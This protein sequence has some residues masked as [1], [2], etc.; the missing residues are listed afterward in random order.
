MWQ[1]L[2]T[3]GR[4]GVMTFIGAVVRRFYAD[5]CLMRASALAYTSLLSMVPLFAIM[6]AA[7][8]G[9]G[10]Q[11]RLETLLLSRLSLSEDT[12]M[13]IIGYIDRT[14]VG[15]LGAIGAATLVLTVISVLGTIEASFNHIWRVPRERS[16]WRKVT[17]YLGV[18][19]LTPFLLLAATALTSAGQVKTV[20]QWVLATGYVG[21]AAVW[22]LKLVPLAMNVIALGALYMIM[23]NRRGAPLPIAV[24][25]LFAG[26]AWHLVQLA[27]VSLQIGVAQ[28]DAIYGAVAQLPVTLVWLYVSWAV[29]LAGAELA[30]VLEFGVEAALSRAP[31]RGDAVAL[32]LLVRA[33]DA[34]R[35]G[36][37]GISLRRAARELRVD[38]A[39]VQD[40]A[41]Q[42]VKRGWLVRVE[43][44]P[45]WVVLARDP[46]LVPLRDVVVSGG[47]E[48]IPVRCD[49]R[50]RR[51]LELGDA[52]FHDALG[53]LHLADVLGASEAGP[54]QHGRD[55]AA[56]RQ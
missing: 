43:G 29:V 30:A 9:L 17:D 24:G 10:V 5:Q 11:H 53:G 37:S 40:A 49:P 22:L 27:Y 51:V 23:P 47:S 18:V 34:F 25:A 36:H 16:V 52:A 6:F 32:H 15:T 12:T 55:A 41:E 39:V 46:T 45:D 7:L 21:T 50:V 33:G 26:I 1:R 20:V 31:V 48:H 44:H 56:R 54:E 42:L 3:V 19:L 38:L 28:Y 35:E 13:A 2:H 4:A 14:N 8:K